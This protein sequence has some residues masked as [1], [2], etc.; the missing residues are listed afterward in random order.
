MH[1]FYMYKVCDIKLNKYFFIFKKEENMMKKLILMILPVWLFILT[2]QAIG[3]VTK[4]PDSGKQTIVHP[5]GSVATRLFPG[6][7]VKIVRPDG[8][9]EIWRP[10]G[11]GKIVSPDG[12]VVTRCRD[13]FK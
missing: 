7:N 1:G 10:D 4:L 11:S 8:I 12:T 13:A 2:G 3:G 9:I 6:G 5:D